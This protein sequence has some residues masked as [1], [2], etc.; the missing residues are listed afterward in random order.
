MSGTSVVVTTGGRCSGT[1]WM[2]ARDAAQH[3]PVSSALQN[4]EFFSK[5]SIVLRGRPWCSRNHPG[6]AGTNLEQNMQNRLH[7]YI[8]VQEE[9]SKGSCYSNFTDLRWREVGLEGERQVLTLR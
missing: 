2:G 9:K 8:F 1:E 5:T 4:K 3:P 6:E 7:V